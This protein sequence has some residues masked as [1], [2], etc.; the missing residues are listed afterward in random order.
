MPCKLDST[1]N[2]RSFEKYLSNPTVNNVFG[3]KICQML[4][5]RSRIP[6]A[7]LS[8]EVVHRPRLNSPLHFDPKNIYQIR[9]ER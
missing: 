7:S 9:T 2:L 1:E 4:A 5:L 3:R 8:P 6:F